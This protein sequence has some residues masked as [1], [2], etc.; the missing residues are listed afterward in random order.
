MVEINTGHVDDV[1]SQY[2]KRDPDLHRELRGKFAERSVAE[3]TVP[4]PRAIIT[5]EGVAPAAAQL[6]ARALVETIVRP[7]ARPVMLIQDNHITG[8]FVG[9]DSAV[10]KD[11]IT[12]QA[13]LAL[14]DKCI[15][16]VAN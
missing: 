5:P 13:T 6:G 10:W 2:A 7:S 15:L 9:P 1:I 3:I 4:R 8:D 14:L 11:R 16:C 12:N